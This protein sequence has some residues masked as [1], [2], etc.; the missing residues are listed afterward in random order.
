MKKSAIPWQ[1][2]IC[3]TLASSP[4]QAADFLVDTPADSVDSLPGDGLCADALGTCSLRAAIMETNALAG[5][6]TVD[7]PAGTYSLTRAG[8][9]ENESV[10]GD[11]DITD[12][13]ILLGA[14]V[15]TTIIDAGALDRVLDLRSAPMRTIA[16]Q[17]LTLRNG[18][19]PAGAP[20]VDGG[21]GLMVGIGVQL[22]LTDVVV[23]DNHM[24]QHTGGVAI[25]NRGCLQALRTRIVNNTD[26]AATGSGFSSS[27]GVSTTG[28][29]SCLVLE[30]SELSGNRGDQSG[31]IHVTGGA[32]IILR[33]SLIAQN[34][35]RFSGAIEISRGIEVRLEN[36]TIS[37]NAGNPGAILN[38][39]GT[40]LVLINSTV[41]G[42]HGS[43]SMAVVGGIQDVHGG[44]GLTFLS[45]TILAGNG[46][47]FSAD[48]CSK[49]Q[50]LD[51]GNIIGTTAGCQYSALP[52]DQINAD[53][54]LGPLADNG[55]LS[56]SHL[57][58][59]NAIDHGAAAPCLFLDQRRIGRPLDGDGDGIAQCDVGAV[60]LRVD[61][62]FADGFEAE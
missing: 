13:L 11:L 42:N 15:S 56:R 32:S 29:D 51:G 21:G 23:A 35:A 24:T 6:D 38:D 61:S 49:G 18:H 46:P 31:A 28:E 52:G 1:L 58:G 59:P 43:N 48:D 16:V 27:G 20:L 55:G 5:T 57:P 26:T 17:G 60:E 10:S 22:G 50:S 41:T 25:D 36:T 30:D 12:D 7:I 39:G 33:R 44:F 2:V 4:L 53:P 62:I 37:D 8:S 45:N 14:D 9:G 40:I 47:G 3:L 54:G 19:L 34:E